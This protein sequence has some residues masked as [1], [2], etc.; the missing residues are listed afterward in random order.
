MSG[1][2][3]SDSLECILQLVLQ[4]AG[5][6][7]LAD[8]MVAG[9]IRSG[10]LV[11][12]FADRL[13][14]AHCVAGIVGHDRNTADARH[15]PRLAFD[16]STDARRTRERGGEIVDRHVSKSVEPVRYDFAAFERASAVEISCAGVDKRAFRG[17]SLPQKAL[18]FLVLSRRDFPLRGAG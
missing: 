16:L 17:G 8:Y 11:R 7:R 12:L 14:P 9:P 3:S 2:F 10:K 4:G 6:A 15:V 5:I 13:H 18:F 1:P